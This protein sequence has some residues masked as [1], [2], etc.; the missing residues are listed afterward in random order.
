MCDSQNPLCAFRSVLQSTPHPQS[1]QKEEW[2]QSVGI[3]SYCL[4]WPTRNSTPLHSIIYSLSI[5]RQENGEDADWL[6]QPLTSDCGQYSVGLHSAL[7]PHPDRFNHSSLA[8]CHCC[9]GPGT[10][11]CPIDAEHLSGQEDVAQRS[12]GASVVCWLLLIIRGACNSSTKRVEQG[13]RTV[14]IR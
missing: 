3:R 9:Y 12:K 6:G 10:L 8:I 14:V 1:Q 11:C 7:R 4:I 5:R 13:G 2:D